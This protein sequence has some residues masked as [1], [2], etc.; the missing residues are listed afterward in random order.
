MTP[1]ELADRAMAE[2][3]TDEPLA[4]RLN[5]AL[6]R[7]SPLRSAVGFDT[8]IIEMLNDAGNPNYTLKERAKSVTEVIATIFCL[9]QG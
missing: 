7:L 4:E 3:V 5:A 1:I 2:L 9:C 6:K 8:T